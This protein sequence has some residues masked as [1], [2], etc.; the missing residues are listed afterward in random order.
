MNFP[1]YIN[2]FN[3]AALREGR[4]ARFGG[5]RSCV[6]ASPA[7]NIRFK[8][9]HRQPETIGIDNSNPHMRTE[10]KVPGKPSSNGDTGN[11]EPMVKT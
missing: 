3:R 10:L 6:S 7:S 5:W 8:G 9:R 1:F 4:R 11:S 2:Q